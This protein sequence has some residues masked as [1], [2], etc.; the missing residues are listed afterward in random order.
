MEQETDS[1]SSYGGDPEGP[2]QPCSGRRLQ[3]PD[4]TTTKR[5]MVFSCRLVICMCIAAVAFVSHHKERRG[6]SQGREVMEAEAIS[7]NEQ[8]AP[9][10]GSVVQG[11]CRECSSTSKAC[12]QPGGELSQL[13]CPNGMPCCSMEVGKSYDCEVVP[14]HAPVPA[15]ATGL[16]PLSVCQPCR[17]YEAVCCTRGQL[18]PS[19]QPCCGDHASCEAYP[20]PMPTPVPTPVPAGPPPTTNLS[21][22]AVYSVEWNAGLRDGFGQR[23]RTKLPVVPSADMS[24]L[25]SHFKGV[26]AVFTSSCSLP[27]K[28]RL[29]LLPSNSGGVPLPG[30]GWYV[31]VS[32]C[33]DKFYTNCY[34]SGGEFYHASCVGG[35]FV[36][37]DLPPPLCSGGSFLADKPVF[38]PVSSP[39]VWLVV[40]GLPFSLHIGCGAWN[41]PHG[42]CGVA[43]EAPEI[44]SITIS[45]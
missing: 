30:K 17:P 22:T 9:A 13:V 29:K 32:S 37:D 40:H 28:V 44:K 31:A 5:G 15:P 26:V 8:G 36:H 12:C 2:L 35:A 24:R 45:F 25:Y 18:C 34:G 10:F 16:L 39:E 1:T 19:G 41:A 14:T 23:N 21:P 6:F 7:L 43:A 3:G 38:V 4:W 42:S 20:T 27:L 33:S 11:I